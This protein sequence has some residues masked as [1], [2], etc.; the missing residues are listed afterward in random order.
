MV[1]TNFTRNERL[2]L[3]TSLGVEEEQIEIVIYEVEC[4]HSHCAI[5]GTNVFEPIASN[6]NPTIVQAANQNILIY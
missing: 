2:D 5:T 3:V 1:P 4:D 6:S